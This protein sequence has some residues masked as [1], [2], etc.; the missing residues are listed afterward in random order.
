MPR[1]GKPIVIHT[2]SAASDTLAILREEGASDVG[3]VIHCFS[4]DRDFAR[5]ALDMDFDISF[6][7]IVTFK[8]ARQIQD[9]AGWAPPDRIMVET[10]SPYLAPVPM[11]GKRNEPAFVAH[12]ARHVAELRGL[13]F[14]DLAHLTTENACRRFGGQLTSAVASA[15]S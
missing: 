8:N 15:A 10:D 1:L 12:V 5:S 7:G 14:E 6:S 9:V 2:R 11:R 3:G 4:E 13:A